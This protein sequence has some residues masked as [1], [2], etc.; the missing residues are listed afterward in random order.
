LPLAVSEKLSVDVWLLVSEMVFAA[1]VVPTV[2]VPNASV[3]GLIVRGRLPVPLRLI[4]CGESGALSLI[5]S[6]PVSAPFTEGVKVTFT[7]Q[8]APAARLEPHVLV[9]IAKL[10]VAAIEVILTDAE[11]VF[12]NVTALEALVVPTDCAANDKVRGDGVTMGALATVNGR[13]PNAAQLAPLGK[14]ST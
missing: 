7:L 5:A 6:E 13:N 3:A 10:P 11:L 9:A 14:S 2:T 4:V 8:V 12:L 1:E